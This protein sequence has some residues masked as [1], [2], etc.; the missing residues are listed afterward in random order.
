MPEIPDNFWRS[1]NFLKNSRNKLKCLKNLANYGKNNSGLASRDLG[2][3][4]FFSMLPRRWQVW[5]SWI[6]RILDPHGLHQESGSDRCGVRLDLILY[7]QSRTY[8]G[9]LLYGMILRMRCLIS[10]FHWTSGV[11]VD[12]ASIDRF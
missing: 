12:V 1:V 10:I 3:F 6:H 4:S 8:N 7:S 2:S 9:V 5:L 11:F